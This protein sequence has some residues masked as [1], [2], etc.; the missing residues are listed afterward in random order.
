MAALAPEL[1][2]Q[3]DPGRFRADNLLGAEDWDDAL[4][5]CLDDRLDPAHLFP[6]LEPDPLVSHAHFVQTPPVLG[7]VVSRPRPPR[8][9]GSPKIRPFPSPSS[10]PDPPWHPEPPRACPDLQVK[11]EPDS[12]TSSHCSDSSCASEPPIWVKSEPDSPTSSHCSDS[13]CASEPPIWAP[14]PPEMGVKPEPPPPLPCVRAA[15]RQQRMIK[16]RESASASRRR[17]KEYLQGLERRL[18]LALAE[19]D[20][21]RRDNGA[22]RRRLQELLGQPAP[23]PPVPGSRKLACVG[24]LLLLLAFHLSPTSLPRPGAPPPPGGRGRRHLLG[25][26]ESGTPPPPRFGEE[27]PA[28]GAWPRAGEGFR[29]SSLASMSPWDPQKPRGTPECLR[30]NRTESLRYRGGFWGFQGA[31]P[32]K[33]LV[34]AEPP[35]TERAPPGQLQL[36]RGPDPPE[37]RILAAID[38]RDDT[39]YVVSFRRDHLLLPAR[40]HNKTSRPKMSLVMPAAA[41][42]D[43]LRGL[44]AMMQ[45]DCEVIDTRVIHVR[46]RRA[47]PTARATPPHRP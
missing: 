12:P 36:Y 5:G 27:P 6:S 3:L 1:L 11:S 14:S 10:I 47:P 35:R 30:F 40:S 2:V 33:G 29:N 17:R 44:Q 25:V 45:V 18:H 26:Q 38:R 13:S 23:P 28:R 22:L 19:N 9:E 7:G 4:Y 42:N 21:L 24:A 34:P 43:S 46:R 37:P 41:L 32:W 8:G 31:S 16:N 39:F 20:R 15:R